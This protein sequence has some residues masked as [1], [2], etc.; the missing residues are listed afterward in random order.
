MRHP[1]QFSSWN[2][3][4]VT[5][6]RVNHRDLLQSQFKIEYLDI[7]L[8]PLLVGRLRNGSRS[9]FN[10]V[11]QHYLCRCFSVLLSDFYQ[12]RVVQRQDRVSGFSPGSRRR[13]ERTVGCDFYITV[14]AEF[15]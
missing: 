11:P 3:P 13:P 12:L 5:I 9:Y 2:S 14:F 4:P 8:N 7:L 6:E 1:L 15:Y 10:Q